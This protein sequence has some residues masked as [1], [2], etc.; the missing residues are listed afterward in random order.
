M[1]Q[2]DQYWAADYS[3][4]SSIAGQRSA[5]RLVG[6]DAVGQELTDPAARYTRDTLRE[7]L[8]SVVIAAH[9]QD[10]CCIIGI[11]HQFSV[12]DGLYRVLTGATWDR[13]EHLTELLMHGSG[14]LPAIVEA[15]ASNARAWVAAANALLSGYAPHLGPGPF[16]GASMTPGKKWPDDALQALGITPLRQVEQLGKGLKPLFKV[17]TTG[18][19]ELQSLCG[20]PHLARLLASCR[21]RAI[22][23][24]IWP[25]HG[26]AVPARTSCLAEVYPGLFTRGGTQAKTHEGD[27][28][29]TAQ[30][31]WIAD[32]DGTLAGWLL[33]AAAADIEARAKREGWVLGF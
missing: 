3:G 13:W 9:A 29:A 31:L 6:Y 17:G 25:F 2:F 24:H 5:I 33:A 23:L 18:A 4:S 1:A 30:A 15:P 10:E 8:L 20:I 11:D 14:A 27:A 16:W 32:R 28:R 26:W 19:V 7:T 12:P 21:D 22:P